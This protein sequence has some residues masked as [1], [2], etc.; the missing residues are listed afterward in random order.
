VPGLVRGAR[1]I[2]RQVIVP[3]PMML[4]L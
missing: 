1:Y 4:L 2:I 3:A